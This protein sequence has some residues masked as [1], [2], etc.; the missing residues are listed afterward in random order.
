M[1]FSD[2]LLAK[3]NDEPIQA[4]MDICSHVSDKIRTYSVDAQANLLLEAGLILDRMI[5]S[6]LIQ[7][8]QKLPPVKGGKPANTADFMS[9]INGVNRDLK[10]VVEHNKAMQFQEQIEQRLNRMITGSFGYELT[11]GDLKEVQA[12]LDKLRSA[13]TSSTELKEDHRQRLLKRLEKVQ[14]ELHKK[15]STLDGLYCL[16]IEAS[17]VAGTIGKN[18]E[19]IA[20][21]AKAIAGIT[22]R[23]HS[24]T[25]GLPSGATSPL[26]TSDVAT[27]LID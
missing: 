10:A 15:L 2:E 11:D 19:P 18:A 14:S 26:L 6:N 27:N 1:E 20:K 5:K 23:T 25:E 8:T 24:H 3:I 4:G 7:S 17:I 22:W 21:V 13:I 12:L 16:A 9:F